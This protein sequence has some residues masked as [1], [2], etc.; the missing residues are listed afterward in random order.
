MN[1]GSLNNEGANRPAV[2]ARENLGITISGQS[3]KTSAQAITLFM[4]WRA[5]TLLDENGE[6]RPAH[7]AWADYFN[8]PLS[9]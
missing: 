6:A 5:D 8:L 4:V 7:Q 1:C 2:S 9:K 3:T